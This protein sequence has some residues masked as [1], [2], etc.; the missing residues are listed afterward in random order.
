MKRIWLTDVDGIWAAMFKEN[1][2]HS[3]V[4]VIPS[5]KWAAPNPARRRLVALGKQKHD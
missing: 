4:Y 1:A 2:K 5:C 3:G